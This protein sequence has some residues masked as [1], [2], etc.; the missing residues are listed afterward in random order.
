MEYKS[1]SLQNI[2]KKIENN[3]YI[4][5]NFQRGF[6]WDLDKQ[7]KLIASF[8]VK[9]PI[10][11][12]LLLEGKRNDFSAR[13][14][15]EINEIK[16]SDNFSC[17]YILDGQQR[18]STLKN[19]F[20]NLYGCNE[21]SK[22]EWQEILNKL[23]DKLRVRWFL[24]IDNEFFGFNKLKFDKNKLETTEPQKLLDYIVY[25]K[26][27]KKD[28]DKWWHPAN[29]CNY[30][31]IKEEA[32][33]ENLIPLFTI[34]KKD[35]G[36]HKKILEEI[37]F[38]QMNNI[39]LDIKNGKCNI[40]DFLDVEENYSEEKIER[41]WITYAINW[42]NAVSNYLHDLL[43]AKIPYVE[44]PSKEIGRAAAIFEE[45]NKGGLALSTYDLLVAKTAK[46]MNGILTHYILNSF[47][48]KF[49]EVKKFNKNF[50]WKPVCM[51]SGK[52]NELS[53]K[54]QDIFL[55]TIAILI[56]GKING[57]ISTL[58]KEHLYQSSILEI[59]GQDIVDNL[60]HI[61]E[62][63]KRAYAFLQFRLGIISE[64]NI[65]YIYMILPIIYLLSYDEIWKDKEKLD[66]LEAWYW[67]SFFSGEFRESQDEKFIKNLQ[68][69]Y[70]LFDLEN[71]E[72]LLKDK[73]TKKDRLKDWF[74]KEENK[75]DFNKMSKKVLDSEDYS[76]LNTLLNP[77]ECPKAMEDAIL[78]Y[79]LSK[80]PTDF[81]LNNP[82]RLTAYYAACRKDELLE[83]KKCKKY[84][85]EIHHIIP[86]GNSKKIG[87]STKKLRKD[88]N[89]I[90]NSPLN[91][92]YI[93]ECANREISDLDVETY[94]NQLGS[95]VSDN[96]LPTEK[97]FYRKKEKEKDEE[98]YKRL[99]EERFNKIRDTLTTEIRSLTR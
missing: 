78:Q 30:K 9:I 16:F 47:E 40:K 58:K 11:S 4:L 33:K 14:L 41:E 6:V 29:D 5:P 75:Y 62:A 88:K 72:I 15:C 84:N 94:L 20:Y 26:I 22:N 49:E 68:M 35:D 27:T 54:F 52:E 18:L 56:Y 71:Y 24:K 21:D 96:C 90:L 7:K 81:I 44:L 3:E 45:I 32:V 65:R 34:F 97:N 36:L 43:E 28:K 89:N 64:K 53:K 67:S 13:A 70:I 25:K 8:L 73:E 10:G 12:T 82:H 55:N 66:L 48:E 86:L 61:L 37:A 83:E 59:D 80:E 57:D 87:D 46:Y 98:Y 77:S 92:V 99:L 19:C 31:D 42:A 63:I 69:L 85:L 50:N 93:S 2:I 17:V 51:L 60:D 95:K 91:L 23:F 76:D 1:I 38:K 79:C 39:K 74:N